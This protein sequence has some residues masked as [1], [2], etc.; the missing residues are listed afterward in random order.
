[1]KNSL[2]IMGVAGC[3][4]SS[5]GASVAHTCNLQLVEGDDFHGAASRDKMTKGIALLDSDRDGWLSALGQQLRN[6]P[7]GAVLTCSAL[8]KSYR[9][10]LRQACP[11]LLFVFM[12]ISRADALARVTARGKEHFFSPSLID[13]QFDTLESPVGEPGVLRV[14]AMSN[15]T[16]LRASAVAWLQQLSASGLRASG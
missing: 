5:L 8:K 13:N 9:D 11:R 4:K 14:D 3:G 6:H 10:R 15:L 16:E 7:G 12:D 2:V 1:M